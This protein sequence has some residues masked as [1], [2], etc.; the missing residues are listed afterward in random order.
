VTG[1]ADLRETARRLLD[2]DAAEQGI[3]AVLE[4]SALLAAVAALMRP[5]PGREV[6]DR[7]P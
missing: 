5:V 6:G 4:D 2:R 1:E 7:G 3:P